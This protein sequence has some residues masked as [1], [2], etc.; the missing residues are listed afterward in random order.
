MMAYLTKKQKSIYDYLKEFIGDKGYAPSIQEI[1]EY[2]GTTSLSTMHKQL[3][4]LENRGFIKRT[5]NMKR[6]IELVKD[7]STEIDPLEVPVMGII[8]EANPIETTKMIEY[9]RLPDKVTRGK[10]VYM[11]EVKGKA[12]EGEKISNGDYVIIESTAK[13]KNDQLALLRL[14]K[15]NTTLRRIWK[16]KGKINLALKNP[17]IK[18]IEIDESELKILGVV[19]GVFRSFIEP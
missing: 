15:N 9:M 2:F 11:L 4:T 19:V 14:D 12:Y 17:N 5:P 18:T 1:C 16:D 3:V 6:A 10:R 8:S 13:F 7:E